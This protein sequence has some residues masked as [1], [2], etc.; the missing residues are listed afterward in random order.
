M[1]RLYYILFHIV[2]Y[3]FGIVAGTNVT[4]SIMY[5]TNGL[6]LIIL[7][8]LIYLFALLLGLLIIRFYFFRFFN[9]IF[10]D[11]NTTD[12]I[13][14]TIIKDQKSLKTKIRFEK[15]NFYND[16][17]VLLTAEPTLK[18][19]RKITGKFNL[20]KMEEEDLFLLGYCFFNSYID[21][22]LKTKYQKRIREY[23]LKKLKKCQI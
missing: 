16:E 12:R 1:K 17:N 6:L 8:I 4:Y 18:Q 5:R 13:H 2:Y 22:N 9:N 10:F 14:V 23:K 7:S 3:I 15:F 11:I 21:D 19:V 20:W